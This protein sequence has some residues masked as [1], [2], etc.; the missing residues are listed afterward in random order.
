MFKRMRMITDNLNPMYIP[1]M[2]I[3]ARHSNC[4]MG[5]ILFPGRWKLR[6]IQRYTRTGAYTGLDSKC[7]SV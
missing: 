1:T 3:I 7:M 2:T 4:G 6:P 5:V